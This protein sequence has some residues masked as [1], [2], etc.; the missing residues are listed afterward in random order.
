VADDIAYNAHD[1]DDAVRAGLVTLA[2][3]RDVPLVGPFVCEVLE[4]WPDIERS[5]QAHE[6]QR[7]L[8]TAGV[9]DVIA[10]GSTELARARPASADEVRQAGRALIH[11]SRDLAE[12]EAA[13]KAFMFD[14]VYRSEAVMAP[15]RRSEALLGALFDR[16]FE[17]GDMPGRWRAAFDAAPTQMARA[18]IVA[19]FVA[20]M[21]DP[22][23]ENEYSRLF[24]GK[25]PVG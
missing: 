13:L 15:V 22:Y 17:A 18:R 21:T 8:I 11:F 23:A 6:V 7:R 16:Y 3:L 2:E 5:R 9:E 12:A 24:D 4:R 19:D 20:G 10:T 14:H 1:I 25:G